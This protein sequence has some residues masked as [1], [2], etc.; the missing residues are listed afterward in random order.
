MNIN[1]R[2]IT[3]FGPGKVLFQEGKT[4]C[5]SHRYCVEIDN[6]PDGLKN[7]QDK[8]G[9]VFIWESEMQVVESK[10]DQGQLFKESIN[11]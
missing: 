6:V 5:F 10:P 11:E 2:V 3:Q 8:Y 1:D 4:G 7:L 9:G